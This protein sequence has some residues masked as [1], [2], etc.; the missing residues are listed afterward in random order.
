MYISFINKSSNLQNIFHKF[1]NIIKKRKL[2]HYRQTVQPPQTDCI[3]S[4]DKLYKRHR[5][6][7]AAIQYDWGISTIRLGRLYSLSGK[8]VQTEWE[9]EIWKSRKIH[10]IFPVRTSFLRKS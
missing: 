7:G 8:Y 1:V 4:P 6:T 2:L 3:A 10:D 5:Q 9:V